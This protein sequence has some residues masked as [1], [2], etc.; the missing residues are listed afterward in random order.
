MNIEILGIVKIA[1][2][3]MPYSSAYDNN[4]VYY[5]RLILFKAPRVFI[6]ENKGKFGLLILY[7]GICFKIAVETYFEVK[8]NIS[9]S[10]NSELGIAFGS[11]RKLPFF[12]KIKPIQN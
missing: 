5:K 7:F 8:I 9:L 10:K 3:G 2:F 6:I 11:G 1:K 4:F 12:S